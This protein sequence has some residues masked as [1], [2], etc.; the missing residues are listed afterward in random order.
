MRRMAAAGNGPCCFSP[1]G[2]ARSQEVLIGVKLDHVHRPC[3][4][5][6][7]G[8]HLAGSQIPELRSGGVEVRTRP[9]TAAALSPLFQ[10]ELFIHTPPSSVD[11]LGT[12]NPRQEA[13]EDPA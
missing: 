3:V 7:L 8:H 1:V 2:A 9:G 12:C 6:E 4:A 13:D 5:R 11:R 10:P